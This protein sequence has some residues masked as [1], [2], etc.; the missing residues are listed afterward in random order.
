MPGGHLLGRDLL[1]DGLRPR[2]RFFEGEE[3]HWRCLT[4]TVTFRTVLI[5]DWCDVARKSDV[6]FV[7]GICA[8]GVA[9]GERD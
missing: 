8:A 1:F 2:P 7:T 3:R 6:L 9:E 4:R 5:E